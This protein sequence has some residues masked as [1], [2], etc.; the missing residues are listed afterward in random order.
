M[1]GDHLCVPGGGAVGCAYRQ[2]SGRG[3]GAAKPDPGDDGETREESQH[4]P[5]LP[6]TPG[7]VL[8]LIVTFREMYL[9]PEYDAEGK[10]P[11]QRPP[12]HPKYCQGSL[13]CKNCLILILFGG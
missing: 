3:L 13:K 2:G 4:S 6:H 5:S 1:T 11:Q 10:Q 8:N 12:H 7:D 9:L